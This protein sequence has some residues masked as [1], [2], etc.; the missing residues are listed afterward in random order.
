MKPAHFPHE[1]DSRDA[2]CTMPTWQTSRY[3]PLVPPAF[4]LPL[5]LL[6]LRDIFDFSGSVVR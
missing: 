1:E 2:I 4:P 3:I 6:T 5:K